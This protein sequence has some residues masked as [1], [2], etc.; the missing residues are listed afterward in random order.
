MVHTIVYCNITTSLVL[1]M[2][3]A[4]I[5]RERERERDVIDC[6][7]WVD[8]ICD[9]LLELNVWNIAKI[10]HMT[11]DS[12]QDFNVFVSLWDSLPEI[13][14]YHQLTQLNSETWLRSPAFS[15]HDLL[16]VFFNSSTN[17]ACSSLCYLLQGLNMVSE[18][19]YIGSVI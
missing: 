10:E 1:S 4:R 9:T 7:N 6:K 16:F 12:L 14:Y 18:F 8:D 17:S 2:F 19:C 11:C 13:G 5:L 3:L 15:L